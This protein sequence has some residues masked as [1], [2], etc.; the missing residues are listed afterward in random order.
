VWYAHTNE[1]YSTL[2]KKL[3][4]N[5]D[6]IWGHYAKQNKPVIE[7]KMCDSTYMKYQK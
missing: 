4:N 5:I 2:K 7:R 3:Y 6:E 1:Y